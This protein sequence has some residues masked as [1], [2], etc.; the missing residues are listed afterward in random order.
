[1]FGERRTFRDTKLWADPS[2][3]P[4]LGVEAKGEVQSGQAILATHPATL[5]TN[6]RARQVLFQVVASGKILTAAS[7]R[8]SRKTSY[9][10]LR[11]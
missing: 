7:A 1:M 2:F 4:E 3:I 6:D 8:K 11:I 5:T 9:A 10:N